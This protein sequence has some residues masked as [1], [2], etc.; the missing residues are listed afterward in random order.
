MRLRSTPFYVVK[1]FERGIV[2]VFGKYRKPVGPGLHFQIPFIEMTR[3]R[4]VREHTMDIMP[5]EVITKD[6]V[7]IKVDGVIWV[8]PGFSEHKKKRKKTCHRGEIFD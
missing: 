2:E 8:R 5:Q 3:I 6:N 4:D 1:E 7:E